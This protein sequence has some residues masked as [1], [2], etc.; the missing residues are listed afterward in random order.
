M[1]VSDTNVWPLHGARLM[2]GLRRARLA[3]HAV[4]LPAGERFKTLATVSDL[5]DRFVDLGMDRATAV[6]ALGGGVITD[7][8]G[9]TAAAYMR[10]VPRACTDDAPGMVDAS[11]G[12]KVAVDHQRGKNLVGA[13]VSRSWSCS[14]AFST[15]PPQW[16]PVAN[17]AEVIKA[18]VIAGQLSAALEGRCRRPG[19]GGGACAAGQ[20]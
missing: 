9:F 3:P 7:M 12:G 18:G 16:K 19:L 20:A 11:V 10:G 4:V 6:I 15:P 8:V 2:A 13:F 5:Y 17:L 1:V 14:P